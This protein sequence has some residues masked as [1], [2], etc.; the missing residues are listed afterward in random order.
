[1]TF[2][3][4]RRLPPR[5][6]IANVRAVDANL[7]DD[8]LEKTLGDL[9]WHRVVRAV[10]ERCAGPR[11]ARLELP[12]AADE[13]G[14][15]RALAE[16]R[17]AAGLL[18]AGE[19]LPLE[20]LRDVREHLARAERM[21]VLEA[22]ALLDVAFTVAAARTLRRFLAA[23]RRSAPLLAEAC[24]TD[25]SLDGLEDTLRSAIDADGTLADH[26]SPELR[27]LR[28]E[29]AN[30][31]GR[32][33]A[34][35]E[36][37]VV[38]HADVLS[39]RFHTIRDGRYVLPVRSDA[40]E[41]IA[42]IVHGTSASGAT[43]FVEPR[44]LVT[45]GNRLRIAQGEMEREVQRILGVLTERV[46]E[47]LPAL[48]AAAD[49][50]DHADLRAA[51]ARFGRDLRCTFPELDPAPDAGASAARE[52]CDVL[53]LQARHPILALDGVD[54]VPNDLELRRGHALVVSGP[55]AGGKTVALK[56]LGLA[57]LMVRA[58]LPL[59]VAEGSRCA[60]FDRVLSDVGDDQS[61]ARNLS[62]FSAHV[63][64]LAAILAA[65]GP[66]S[67]VL[68]DELAGG[69]DPEEGAALACAVVDGLC[70]RGAA[71]V[72]TTHYEALKA[73]ALRD[74]RLRN[75]SVGFDVATMTPTFRLMLD[76]PG[77][78]SALAVA[79]RFGIPEDVLATARRVLPDTAR[80]FDELVHK[81]EAEW[82]AL[83]IQRSALEAETARV[84]EQRAA[85]EHEREGLRAREKAQ[86]SRE[87][88]QLLALVRKVR[89]EV[90]EARARLRAARVDEAEV[91]AARRVVD[92]A[93]AKLALGGELCEPGASDAK[94]GPAR[95][96]GP[97]DPAAVRV[98][99]RVYVP[100][101]RLEAEVVELPQKGR[102]RVA[103]G[104]MRVWVGLDEIRAAPG[105]GTDGAA[106]NAPRH[107]KGHAGPSATAHDP[108]G[109]PGGDGGGPVAEP[110]SVAEPPLP[111]SHDGNTID[112]RGMRADD[113]VS[114]LESFLDRLYGASE[115][116]GF[117][118]HGVGSGALRDAIRAHLAQPSPY[119]ARSR[120]GRPEEG[121]D[122]VTIV[123]VR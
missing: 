42:G 77:A 38:R 44:A 116:V 61:L 45:L 22:H 91:D 114:M 11:R 94:E 79:A 86:V 26:A 92:A 58:G 106:S 115:P 98:G 49:A 56:T 43:V 37:M 31:R 65:A 104:P 17:E 13:A 88:E 53:L 39:D 108:R 27:A 35:L 3:Q 71:V 16:T 103:A 118:L 14:A 62:T 46:R 41:R 110:A 68:L 60:H 87:T 23:R 21:G 100:R 50:L 80:S 99:L 24:A 34:R 2:W 76:V 113:A 8:A 47:H 83:A 70:Q 101:L 29:V 5:R 120:P 74:P 18:E 97:V 48:H 73:L 107:G 85:L 96:G 112:L 57:A 10:A 109:R 122:R 123:W 78:S 54:V 111:S 63:T 121:G 119:V 51:S 93:A 7:P 36:E 102:L 90:R 12:L 69:T 82:R 81:L 15:R 72:V 64:N 1:V 19:P 28:L 30:L 25:P 9:E 95:N 59:S 117:V 33:V 52:R 66:R 20:G 75:A 55:N 89:D 4:R 32:I 84:A 6:N 105:G 40:H 67:L